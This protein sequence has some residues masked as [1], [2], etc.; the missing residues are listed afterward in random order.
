MSKW[1]K[2]KEIKRFVC[3]AVGVLKCVMSLSDTPKKIPEKYVFSKTETNNLRVHLDS[4]G[5]VNA[6]GIL[7]T[8]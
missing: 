4:V 6:V 2:K 5:R 8:K 3:E 1:T 7:T